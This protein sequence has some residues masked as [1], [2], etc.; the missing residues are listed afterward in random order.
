MMTTYTSIINI[1]ELRITNCSLE[2]I[3]YAEDP[4]PIDY[5]GHQTTQSCSIIK[6]TL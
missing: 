1:A 2:L 3:N 4:D 6:S 5:S